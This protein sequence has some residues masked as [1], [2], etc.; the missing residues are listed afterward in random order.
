MIFGFMV[1]EFFFILW[2]GLTQYKILYLYI[3]YY[4][5]V[6][7]TNSK[8][9]VNWYQIFFTSYIVVWCGLKFMV[10]QKKLQ[11]TANENDF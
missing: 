1:H 9:H 2:K 4:N 11:L 5:M 8:K 6:M 7:I 10:L 3:Q